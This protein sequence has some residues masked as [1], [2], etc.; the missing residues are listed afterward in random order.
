MKKMDPI[1]AYPEEI[2]SYC[3]YR[4][5]D[6]SRIPI[7]TLVTIYQTYMEDIKDSLL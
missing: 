7:K 5:E 1:M 3:I 4:M 6:M 2:E